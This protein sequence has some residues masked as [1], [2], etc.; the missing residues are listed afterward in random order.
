MFREKS[1]IIA[2]FIVS[3]MN[4]FSQQYDFQLTARNSWIPC[5]SYDGTEDYKAMFNAIQEYNRKS[6]EMLEKL[7]L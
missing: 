1:T 7:C 6:E 2:T 3:I 5:A 4:D